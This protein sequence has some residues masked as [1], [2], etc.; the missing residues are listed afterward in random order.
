MDT[1]EKTS[2]KTRE[3]RINE[4]L[5]QSAAEA[6]SSI[7]GP[8]LST[9]ISDEPKE[10]E[11][12]S[13][14]ED[15]E[16]ND[17]KVRIPRSRLK[18]LTSKVSE[19]E[20]RLAESQTYQERVAA[21]EAQINSN[22]AHEELPD[23]WKQD[24]GEGDEQAKAY[25]AF[26]RGLQE[27]LKQQMEVQYAEQARA[28]AARQERVRS[29][30][31][32]FDEQM[33]EL[34]DTLGRNL[35]DNQKSELLEIVEE[36]SPQE[37][38]SYTAYMPISKAYKLWQNNQSTNVAKKEMASIA[39]IQSSGNSSQQSQSSAPPQWGDWRKRFGG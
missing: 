39:G 23:W 14:V 11:A 1:P 9:L 22:R 3:E 5:S 16:S 8:S 29:T 7:K 36:Y 27:E 26:K 25:K 31:Q 38:G 34:E 33:E 21:L 2:P 24:Y 12:E 13:E 10:V 15:D 4:L 18:T 6:V 17:K 28:E 35:T 20:A 32:S 37:D 19:L 30:E